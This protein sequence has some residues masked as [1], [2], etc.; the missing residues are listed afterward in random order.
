MYHFDCAYLAYKVRSHL[1]CI[2][3]VLLPNVQPIVMS[4]TIAL[5]VLLKDLFGHNKLH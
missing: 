5:M 1:K 3:R 4:D 2:Q